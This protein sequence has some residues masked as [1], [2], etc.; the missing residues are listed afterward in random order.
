M[1]L[2]LSQYRA[3]GVRL[4]KKIKTCT[5]KDD[6]FI[7]GLEVAKSTLEFFMSDIDEEITAEYSSFTPPNTVEVGFYIKDMLL[8][9]SEILTERF[10]R[11]ILFVF[12][13]FLEVYE[14]VVC[15]IIAN[16]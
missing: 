11:N 6:L 10:F 2:L 16:E 3:K 8:A 7:W 4:L 15:S 12:D 9:P 5:I 14:T 1:T 13:T